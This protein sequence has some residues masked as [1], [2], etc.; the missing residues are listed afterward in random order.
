[1]REQCHAPAAEGLAQR[2]FGDESIDAKF[3]DR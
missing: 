3:H 1:M 2:A